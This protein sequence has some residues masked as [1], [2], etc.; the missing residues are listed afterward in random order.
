M[1][2]KIGWWLR[3]WADRIDDDN[4]PRLTHLSFTFERGFGIK[5]RTD[6]KGCPLWY[7]SKDDYERAY[8]EADRPA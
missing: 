3:R 1:R 8:D 4:T 6:G 7:L 2:E 5:T